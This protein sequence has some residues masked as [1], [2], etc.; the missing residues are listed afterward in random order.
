LLHTVPCDHVK[1]NNYGQG[2]RVVLQIMTHALELLEINAN[3]KTL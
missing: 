1:H 3:S 2:R